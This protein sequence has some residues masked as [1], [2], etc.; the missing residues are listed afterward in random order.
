MIESENRLVW[1]TIIQTYYV[2][3][4]DQWNILDLLHEFTIEAIHTEAG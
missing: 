4:N 1:L 3:H 2:Q